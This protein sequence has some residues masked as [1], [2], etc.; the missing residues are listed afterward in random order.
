M[1]PLALKGEDPKATMEA[2]VETVESMPRTEIQEQ[3]EFYLHVT[4]TTAV[5]RFIDD[6]EFLIEED[7][8][9]FRSSSRLGH[10]DFGLNKRRM[11]AFGKEYEN[12]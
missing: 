5:F 12:R 7:E 9:H 6:V 1:P 2:L 11:N 3:D 8:V 10:Y 4:Y